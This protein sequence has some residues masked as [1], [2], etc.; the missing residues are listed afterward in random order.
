MLTLIRVCLVIFLSLSI[1]SCA[2]LP[3][4]SALPNTFTTENIMKIHQGMSSKAV[5]AL[6]KEP[7]NISVSICGRPPQQWTCT[8]WEYGEFSRGRASFTFSGN[9]SSLKLNNFDIDRD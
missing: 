2:E 4:N 8:T 1:S 9:A 5:L 6:F 3:A 7:K